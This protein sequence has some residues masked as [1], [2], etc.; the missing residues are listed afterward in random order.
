MHRAEIPVVSALVV[1]IVFP[2]VQKHSYF[3]PVHPRSNKMAVK[4]HTMED[5][6]LDHSS[7]GSHDDKRI[8]ANYEQTTHNIVGRGQ[9]AT[10][11]FGR[12]LIVIDPVAERK[13]RM[14]L[15]LFI[16][17]PVAILYLFC[18]IDRANIGKPSAA[19]YRSID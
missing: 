13:L 11:K 19:R 18:F 14:K 2:S 6:H 8:I 16:V 1:L 5:A 17:P 9:A 4:N 3:E 12:P 15:D 7:D 10:D